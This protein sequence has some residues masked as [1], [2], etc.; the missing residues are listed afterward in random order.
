MVLRSEC[1]RGRSRGRR[2]APPQP[3]G[4][5]P[6]FRPK[7]ARRGCHLALAAKR[8]PGPAR[9]NNNWQRSTLTAYFR[10]GPPHGTRTTRP[11]PP[12]PQGRQPSP[13]GAGLARASDGR[14]ATVRPALYREGEPHVPWSNRADFGAPKDIQPQ[15]HAD[16]RGW[17]ERLAWSAAAHQKVC[18]H[19]RFHYS[20]PAARTGNGGKT[21]CNVRALLG[22]PISTS[23]AVSQ[24]AQHCLTQMRRETK[25]G[26]MP[27]PSNRRWMQTRSDGTSGWHGQRQRSEKSAFI[28]ACPRLDPGCICGSIILCQPH[29]LASSGKT[30]CTIRHGLAARPGAQRAH[31]PLHS[32]LHHRRL[33]RIISR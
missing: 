25:S 15:M 7:P 28:C 18:V 8:G 32:L 11:E 33:T 26:A 21:P 24:A 29:G 4:V 20:W 3:D 12:A 16:E 1:W 27:H 22:E 13:A 5:R 9:P 2:G 30:P 6:K 19:L 10:Y 14:G 31:R 23:S 17:T